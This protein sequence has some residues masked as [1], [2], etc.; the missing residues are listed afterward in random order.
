MKLNINGYAQ[1]GKDT[2]AGLFKGFGL[3]TINISHEIAKD[4]MKELPSIGPYESWEQ[5]YED[6]VNHRVEWY[7]FI[8]SKCE[9]DK[10]YYVRK[11]LQLGDI[12]CGHRHWSEFYAGRELVDATIWVDASKRGL[13][14]EDPASCELDPTD[15]DFVIDN[16]GTLAETLEQVGSI[17]TLINNRKRALNAYS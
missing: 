2:V 6:R 5:A 9:N 7:N 15:H 3:R 8:R 13:S 11:A 14:K 4:I 16:G 1:H 12:H 17:V 10:T